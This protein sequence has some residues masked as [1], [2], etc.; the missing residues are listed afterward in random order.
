MFFWFWSGY[1][2]KQKLSTSTLDNVPDSPIID[3]H[4]IHKSFWLL[5]K[6]ILDGR[7]PVYRSEKLLSLKYHK[8]HDTRSRLPYR[9]SIPRT[10]SMKRMF[11]YNTV[12]LWN[13]VSE[14]ALV[15]SSNVK[16]F[17]R[18]LFDSVMCK[19]TPDSFKIDFLKQLDIFLK[20]LSMCKFE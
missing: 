7:V 3:I 16:K 2:R 1:A 10:N 4:G 19:L 20:F 5:L 12:K 18:N 8:S 6:K 13:N 9:L 11:V 14:N 15:R 17:K